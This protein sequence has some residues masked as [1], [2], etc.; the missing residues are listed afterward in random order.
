MKVLVSGAGIAGPTLAYWLARAGHEVTIVEQSL[1]LRTGGYLVDF[2]GAG[3]EVAGR[4]GIVPE[5]RKRGYIFDKLEALRSDGSHVATA[6]TAKILKAGENY[7]SI[8]R[9]ELASVIYGSLNGGAELVLGDSV[10]SLNQNA[11]IVE[12]E[13]ESGSTREFDLVVGADGLHSR[14]RELSFGPETEFER[15]LGIVFAAFQVQGYE[16]R[17]E[18]VA[19]LCAGLGYQVLRLT[20]D[21]D[22]TLML[23]SAGYDGERPR[24]RADQEEIFRDALHDGGWEIPAILDAMTGSTDYFFDSV[25]QIR[26]PSWSLGRVVLVGDAGAAPSFM[27]GQGSALAMIEAY[28]LGSQIAG[29][30][31]YTEAFLGYENYLKKFILSKQDAVTKL[32]L[33]FASRNR[34]EL[35]VRNSAMRVMAIPGLSD[36]VMGKS[37]HDRI[38]LPDFEKAESLR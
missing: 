2:W 16:Q 7:V 37:F 34:W 38:R 5:L 17:D 35:F 6:K 3:F 20:L 12:I 31:N 9:S 29:A 4:M 21:R 30:S 36:L 22:R 1:E 13:F 33:A 15:Y 26:M 24:D 32:R 18:G 8:E 23:I 14:I 28:V 11:S 27:A 10:K 19:F 25:S